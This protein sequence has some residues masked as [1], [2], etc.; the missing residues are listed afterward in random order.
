[1]QQTDQ[2]CSQQNSNELI[3]LAP[4]TPA[5]ST[6]LS[7]PASSRARGKKRKQDD[8]LTALARQ[9]LEE[10]NM[11]KENQSQMDDDGKYGEYI[12]CEMRKIKNEMTKQILKMEI[13]SLFLKAHM[14]HLGMASAA[15]PPQ[16][17]NAAY[18]PQGMWSPHWDQQSSESSSDYLTHL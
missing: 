3:E 10:I 17:T 6:P 9:C 1:M 12:A 15:Y 16:M 4:T 13:Q 5:E 18:T 11:D 2:E 7:A 8:E 14:G